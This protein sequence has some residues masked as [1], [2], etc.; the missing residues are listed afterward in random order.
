M[1]RVVRL[2]DDAFLRARPVLVRAFRTRP[3]VTFDGY[4]LGTIFLRRLAA[5]LQISERN[6]GSEF[7]GFN[8]SAHDA[9]LRLD[10]V[11]IRTRRT[12][13]FQMFLAVRILL[14]VVRYDLL[15][16]TPR[17]RRTY[18][19]VEPVVRFPDV[20]HG[21]G[22]AGRVGRELA[23]DAF[24]GARPVTVRTFLTSPF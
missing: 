1:F 13:P 19:V 9:N 23:H 15:S 20:R 3:F 5:V 24:S 12:R 22:P 10:P 7:I 17:T 16:P 18:P 21:T 11:G 4:E 2:A 8:E 6:H 14:V